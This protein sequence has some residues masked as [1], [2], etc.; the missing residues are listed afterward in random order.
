MRNPSTIIFISPLMNTTN[1]TEKPPLPEYK[2]IIYIRIYEMGGCQIDNYE[3]DIM[4]M[5]TISRVTLTLHIDGGTTSIE[6]YN[7]FILMPKV[8]YLDAR[9]DGGGGLLDLLELSVKR[10]LTELGSLTQ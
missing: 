6:V 7:H 3:E 9:G 5:F 10:V 1:L 8:I 2:P 4:S